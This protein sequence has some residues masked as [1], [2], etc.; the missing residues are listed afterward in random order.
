VIRENTVFSVCK[1]LLLVAV[2]QEIPL[3][4]QAGLKTRGDHSA[5][6]A[7]G[8]VQPIQVATRIS[9]SVDDPDSAACR[10]VVCKVSIAVGESRLGSSRRRLMDL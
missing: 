9:G 7:G 10:G 1:D 4:V 6:P 5:C 3:Q 2:V 8:T